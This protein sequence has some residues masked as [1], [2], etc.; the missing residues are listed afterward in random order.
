MDLERLSPIQQFT[1]SLLALVFATIVGLIILNIYALDV[2]V[3]LI[4]IE[5]L[6]LVEFTQRH[7]LRLTWR[8][9]MSFFLLFC[10]IVLAILMFQRVTPLLNLHL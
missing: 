2:F 4:I 8:K 3:L 1:Y 9:N 6:S 7:Q 5:F 10:V